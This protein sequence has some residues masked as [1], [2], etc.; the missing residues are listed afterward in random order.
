MTEQGILTRQQHNVEQEN[1]FLTVDAPVH[2]ED[3]STL[4]NP[5][6]LIGEDYRTPTPELGPTYI[7]QLSEQV[8]IH[9]EQLDFFITQRTKNIL[10]ELA[11]QPKVSTEHLSATDFV[12]A[13]I[14]ELLEHEE[15]S[16]DKMANKIKSTVIP[17]ARKA[18]GVKNGTADYRSDDVAMLN[19]YAEAHHLMAGIARTKNQDVIDSEGV[20]ISPTKYLAQT[21]MKE[22]LEPA[23][24][25]AHDA[26][27]TRQ[28]EIV[29]KIM[30]VKAFN[31]QGSVH[32]YL[33]GRLIE[34][35]ADLDQVMH[36]KD[37]VF[38]RLLKIHQEMQEIP[39]FEEWDVDYSSEA[40][41]KA[42]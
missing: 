11:F 17:T 25:E 4:T 39:V 32:E 15:E 31:A 2:T 41:P 20:V 7:D 26:F 36:D 28:A 9:Q 42:A 18:K 37:T 38:A 29:R 21:H 12:A 22:A 5:N 3:P 13:G 1:L 30:T 16:H 14:S 10:L 35:E 23:V 8:A 19:I 27:D 24:I 6:I 33:D 34:L 40:Y